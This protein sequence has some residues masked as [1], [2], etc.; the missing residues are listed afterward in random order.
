MKAG[1]GGRFKL[2]YQ[3][4]LRVKGS[5]P[6]SHTILEELVLSLVAHVA[7]RD[8]VAVGVVAR[9]PHQVL[10]AGKD[11]LELGSK[12]STEVA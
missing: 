4:N 11:C 7:L 12:H 5:K 2:F 3:I 1:G 10:R 8:E 9:Q 6:V